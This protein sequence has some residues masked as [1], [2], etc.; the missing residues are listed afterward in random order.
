MANTPNQIHF[1]DPVSHTIESSGKKYYIQN[2]TSNGQQI[3][4]SSEWF[5]SNGIT[6]GMDKKPELMFKTSGKVRE[7]FNVIEGEAVRQ[8]RMPKEFLTQ[9]NVSA[10]EKE[11]KNFYKPIYNGEFMYAKLHRD[12]S[13]FNARR[14]MIKKSELGYGEYRVVICVKGLYIGP[15]NENGAMASL[16][17]RIFQIQY[18]EVNV[19]CLF[20]ASAGM[21]PQNTPPPTP[22]VVPPPPT[23]QPSTTNKKNAR[24]KSKPGATRQDGNATIEAVQSKPG[25]TRQ[26]GNATIEALQHVPMEA[27]PNAFFGDLNV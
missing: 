17:I 2:V 13:F 5:R 22:S 3:M 7:T 23:Q 21:L 9:Q 16:H 11:N 10:G 14:E 25:L 6:I 15:H 18:R 8:L 20:E 4:I 27:F 19:T 1:S 12:C 26:D 24:S